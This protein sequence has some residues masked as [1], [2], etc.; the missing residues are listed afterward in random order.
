MSTRACI[1]R[2]R[3][4]KSTEWVGIYS[5]SDGYPSY[6]GAMIWQVL[7]RDFLSCVENSREVSSRDICRIRQAAV[8][9]FCDIYIG[10]H[11]S[12]WSAFPDKCFCHDPF[13]VMR[14]G[15]RPSRIASENPDPLFIEWIYVLDPNKLTLTIFENQGEPKEGQV[16]KEPVRRKDGRWD[17]GH[18]V[19]WHDKA[20]TVDL[21]GDEPEWEAI[22]AGRPDA[23]QLDLDKV[24]T[25]HPSG[26]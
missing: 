15:I 21:L 22:K 3:D 9:G 23:S 8:R 25:G 16:L 24:D 7:Q 14:D 20:A 26:A 12:G 1:A 13:F 2:A 11:R 18:C 4:P 10:G 6:L 19:C 17:Y 5:H